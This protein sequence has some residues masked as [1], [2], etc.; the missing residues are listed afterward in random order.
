TSSGPTTTTTVVIAPSST[1]STTTVPPATTTTTLA[2]LLGLELEPLTQDLVQPIMLVSP[3]GD[4][5]RFVAERTGVIWLLDEAGTP[6]GEAFLDLRDRVNSGGIE[7]GLLGL[8]F[9]PD[10]ADNG[11]FFVYYYQQGVEQTQ[12]SEFGVGDTPDQANPDSERPLLAFAKPTTRHNGGMLLFGPDGYL[13]MSLGEGG[14]ASV[15]SQDPTRL[16]SSILRIDVDAGDPYGIPPDN[17]Y[18]EGPGAPEVWAKGLRNPWRFSID[19]SLIY[20]GDVG[21]SDLEEIDVV[22]LDGAPYNFGWLRMEGS[23]CFQRGCDPG[24][25]GLTLPVVEYPHSEGCAVTGGFV[26]RGAAI[27]ELAGHYLY[28][29]WCGGWI[30]SFRYQGG[31]AVDHQSRFEDV[32]QINSFGIDSTGELYVLTYEGEVFKIV[33]VR[34]S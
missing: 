24:A 34:E 7:Q 2:P 26:Y 25:E 31:E 8:A 29:D 15:N 23:S 18:V 27:P 4:P 28:G 30:R 10:Y 19:E 32:G 21:H 6:S 1:S 9:H 11:R 33:P 16:L 22:A 12:L 3:P 17:P 5:R 20:I 13:W 14:A